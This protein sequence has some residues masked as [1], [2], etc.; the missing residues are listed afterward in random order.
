MVT[1]LAIYLLLGCLLAEGAWRAQR[2]RGQQ[3]PLGGYLIILLG[4]PLVTVAAIRRGA[5]TRR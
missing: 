1:C 3:L 4:W 5:W 2:R